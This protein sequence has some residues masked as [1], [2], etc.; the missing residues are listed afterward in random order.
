MA[1][2]AVLVMEIDVLLHRQAGMLDEPR[3]ELERAQRWRGVF[4]RSA[5]CRSTKPVRR[6]FAIFSMAEL[7][8]LGK[9]SPTLAN[10]LALQYDRC[11][12]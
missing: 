4:M 2:R 1:K 6:S 12:R 11:R 10:H 9:F 7:A 3:A 5:N 8:N